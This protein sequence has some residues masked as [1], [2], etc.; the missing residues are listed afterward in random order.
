MLFFKTHCTISHVP[1]NLQFY[2]TPRHKTADH[3]S[4][5]NL[6]GLCF[7]TKN[8]VPF[9]NDMEYTRKPATAIPLTDILPNEET[10]RAMEQGER[11]EMEWILQ[12]HFPVVFQVPSPTNATHKHHEELCDKSQ[13]LCYCFCLKQTII[14]FN[15]TPGFRWCL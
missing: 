8:R 3:G 11:F 7:A 5:M 6:F 15:I 13:H 9:P 2:E 4:K 14:F 12:R 1:T 10:W